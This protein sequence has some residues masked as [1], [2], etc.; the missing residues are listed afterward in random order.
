MILSSNYN[1]SK[2]RESLSDGEISACVKRAYNA[3]S[4]EDKEAIKAVQKRLCEI[5]GMGPLS[6]LEVIF[7]ASRRDELTRLSESLRG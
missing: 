4:E 7:A 1:N 2:V 6:A 5:R 3:L